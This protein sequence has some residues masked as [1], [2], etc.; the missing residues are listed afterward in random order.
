MQ[1]KQGTLMISVLLDAKNPAIA[2]QNLASAELAVDAA[3][4]AMVSV[5]GVAA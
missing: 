1:A 4:A 3:K 2:S 5:V